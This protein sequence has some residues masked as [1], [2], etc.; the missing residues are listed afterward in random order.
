MVYG[1][2]ST[3]QAIDYDVENLLIAG[4]SG[5]KLYIWTTS[6]INATS[7]FPTATEVVTPGVNDVLPGA[8]APAFI[9]SGQL[10]QIVGYWHYDSDP[11]APCGGG[12]EYGFILIGKIDCNV[13]RWAFRVTNRE[14]WFFIEY[15][16]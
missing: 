12:C 14:H 9:N 11:D 3:G 2:K 8:N 4:G 16:P 5:T 10:G 6:T 7:Q 1:T 13:C 15:Q